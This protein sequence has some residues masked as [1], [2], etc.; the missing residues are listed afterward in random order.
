MLSS[1]LVSLFTITKTWKK[2]KYEI[3]RVA[4]IKSFQGLLCHAIK[5]TLNEYFL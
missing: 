4:G 3:K 1:F 2:P 5:C